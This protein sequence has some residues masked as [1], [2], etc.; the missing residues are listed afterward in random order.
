MALRAGLSE[1]RI[2]PMRSDITGLDQHPPE[3]PGPQLANS[4]GSRSY[5]GAIPQ[6]FQSLGCDVGSHRRQCP[7]GGEGDKPT[8]SVRSFHSGMKL[9]AYIGNLG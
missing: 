3:G 6:I 8:F 1:D 4:D 7:M 5:Q 9:R 2:V